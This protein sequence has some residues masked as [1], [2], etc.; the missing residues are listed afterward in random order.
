MCSDHNWPLAPANDTILSMRLTG[1]EKQVITAAVR[2]FDPD[3]A[4]WLF[5][6]RV[7]DRRRGGDIDLAVLSSRIHRKETHDIR[8][9]I[10]EHIGEQKI[11]LVVASNRD[12]PMLAVAIENGVPLVE[13]NAIR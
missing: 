3:A 7:D 6:S 1:H 5:G 13:K 4:I 8:H 11:D 2:R 9:Q 12:H 10:R